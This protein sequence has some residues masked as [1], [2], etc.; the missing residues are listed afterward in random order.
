MC[1]YL[2]NFDLTNNY[3]G[4]SLRKLIALTAIASIQTLLDDSDRQKRYFR[5]FNNLPIRAVQNWEVISPYRATYIID[6][7]IYMERA[8]WLFKN[9]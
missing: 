8:I 7:N 3:S 6:W 5:R 1:L 9:L 4:A 2:E